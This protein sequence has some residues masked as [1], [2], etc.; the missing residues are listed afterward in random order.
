M[1][2]LNRPGLPSAQERSAADRRHRVWWSIC[3]GNF[4]PRRRTL[5][6]RRLDGG[7]LHFLDWHASHLLA[8]AVAVVLLSAADAFLT[9]LLIQAGAAEVNPIMAALVYRSVAAFAALKMAMTSISIVVMVFVARYRFM[10]LLSVE[11]VLCGI[12]IAY[13]SLICYE[14]SMLKAEIPFPIF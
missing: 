6:R 12:L 3:Y 5:P 13:G 10:R 2:P 7:R 11:W 14:V 8:V 9:L 1:D 4:N